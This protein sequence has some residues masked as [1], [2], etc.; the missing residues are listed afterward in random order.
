MENP[1]IDGPGG[2]ARQV[3]VLRRRARRRRRRLRRL[4]R[5]LFEF[6]F[7]CALFPPLAGSTWV[8][9]R[10]MV[11]SFVVSV[12]D[13]VSVDG[14]SVRRRAETTMRCR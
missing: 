5:S 8:N 2:V 12:S 3:F 6:E 11:G 10:D 4:G 13:G 9:L 14:G 1:L 7:E